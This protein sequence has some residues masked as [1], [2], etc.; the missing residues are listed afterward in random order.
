MTHFQYEDT[1]VHDSAKD[2][3]PTCRGGTVPAAIPELVLA[4]RQLDSDMHSS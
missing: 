4:L 2:I 1:L 3:D